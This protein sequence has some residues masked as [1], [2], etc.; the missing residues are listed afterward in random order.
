MYYNT[1][2]PIRDSDCTSLFCQWGVTYPSFFVNITEIMIDVPRHEKKKHDKAVKIVRRHIGCR[3]LLR[4]HQLVPCLG[5]LPPEKKTC[6]AMQYIGI[7]LF[8]NCRSQR[9][10]DFEGL[11]QRISPENLSSNSHCLKAAAYY[12]HGM[13]VNLFKI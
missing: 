12:I 3:C 6:F 10:V 2:A 7:F 13:Q 9:L 8:L 4:R 5:A 1:Q 11:L